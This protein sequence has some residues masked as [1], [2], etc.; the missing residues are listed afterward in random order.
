[1]TVTRWLVIAGCLLMAGGSAGWADHPPASGQPDRVDEVMGRYNLHPAFA[2]LGR[3]L[4]N[5][6]GGWLEIP[7]NLD[8]RYSAS[9]TAGSLFTGVAYGLFKGLVRTG[10]GAYEMVT[11]FLP[12]PEGF[13]PILPTLPYF[14]QETKQRPF[15]RTSE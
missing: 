8:Q 4:S 5:A 12:Y 14:Q 2:K 13:A 9:D 10:V 6:L 1:M 7:L 3:G 11:F 15:P